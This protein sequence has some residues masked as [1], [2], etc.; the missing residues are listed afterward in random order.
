MVSI[1]NQINKKTSDISLRCM[2]VNLQ[3]SKTATDHFNQLTME[4]DIDI[5]FIQE[6][7]IYQNQVTG[8]SRKHRTFACGNGR[9]RAAILVA[10]KQID[11]LLISQLSEEDIVVEVIQGNLKFIAASVYLD[12]EN[13]ITMD[14]YKI[15]NILQFAKD[16]GLLVAMDSNARSK[17]WHDVLTNK[18]GR[19]L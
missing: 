17:T 2:Q 9:K 5:A 1:H 14:L 15:E 11:V 18:K 13:E 3:H 8:I 16:G 7:H 6:P 4:M 19:I 10:N 12:I